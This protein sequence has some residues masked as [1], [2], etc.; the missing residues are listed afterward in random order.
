MDGDGMPDGWEETHSLNPLADDAASDPDNDG[1]SNLQ[2]Y[3]RGTDPQNSD[4]DGD[5]LDDKYEVESGRHEFINSGINLASSAAYGGALAWGDFDDD[6]YPD[7]AIGGLKSGYSGTSILH[8]DGQGNFE[9]FDAT[10]GGFLGDMAWCDFDLDGDLDLA[11]VGVLAWSTQLYSARVERN[12]GGVY[13]EAFQPFNDRFGV[14]DGSVS[15]GDLNNDGYPDLAISGNRQSLEDGTRVDL[16]DPV[17]EWFVDSG[18]RLSQGKVAWGD[19]DSD[20]DLDL[21]LSNGSTLIYRND[22]NDTFT[23]V[24]GSLPASNDDLD[25]G[26]YDNDGDLDLAIMSSDAVRVLRNDSGTFVDAGFGIPGCENGGLGWAD[27]DGDGYLDLA[28]CGSR[29]NAVAE[30]YRNV[31]YAPVDPLDPDTDG[32][33]MPDGWEV[34]MGFDPNGLEDGAEDADG[35]GLSNADEYANQTDPFAM[36]TDGDGQNDYEEVVVTGMDPLDA[37][38]LLKIESLRA[39]P[40]GIELK[41]LSAEAKSYEILSTTNLAQGFEP[42]PGG[43]PAGSG[44]HTLFTNAPASGTR[45]YRVKVTAP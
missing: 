31:F 7:L 12:T 33:G 14:Y 16:Y 30:I 4:S 37:D 13:N 35:D 43:V 25:W 24:G 36:D 23:L 27:Y 18:V 32:D 19:Y 28:F 10:T 26:D 1:L 42:L 40:E 2:E 38:S 21:A 6:G 41:W 45:F 11:S 20:G 22:G 3:Q 29:G 9:G 17:N 34:A 8:N 5:G 39:V 15:W 44:G